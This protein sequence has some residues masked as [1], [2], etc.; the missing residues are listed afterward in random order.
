MSVGY[1]HHLGQIMKKNVHICATLD[2]CAEDTRL[3]LV[4]NMSTSKELSSNKYQMR[5]TSRAIP[6]SRWSKMHSLSVRRWQILYLRSIESYFGVHKECMNGVC[7]SPKCVA[8]GWREMR[9]ITLT[10]PIQTLSAKCLFTNIC[11]FISFFCV[12]S[13]WMTKTKKCSNILKFEMYNFWLSVSN[14][15]YEE[16][17]MDILASTINWEPVFQYLGKIAQFRTQTQKKQSELCCT[18]WHW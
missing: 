1:G 17:L 16:T 11:I 12:F 13:T 18:K 14:M 7:W 6:S 8:F 10:E 2:I 15:A 5:G 3:C 9:N 4:M